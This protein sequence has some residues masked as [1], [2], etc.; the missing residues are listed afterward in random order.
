[1]GEKI[2]R[3]SLKPGYRLLWYRIE[4]ILGQGGFGITYL[5][6]DFNLDRKAAIKEYLPIELA[7]REGD[8]SVHPLT[9]NHGKQFKWGLDR[10]LSEARTLAK[11]EHPNIVRVLN[12][13][14]ANNTA[15][16]V[17]SYE[18]GESLQ[19]ILNRRKTLEEGEIMNILFPILGGLD[20]VHEMGFIHRDIKPANIFL[21]KDGSP[22]LLDFG[23]ARQAVGIQT[24]T[25]TSLISPGYA[26][27][28]QYYSK[29]DAQ[30]PWTDIYGL[31]ATLY[32]A[33]AGISP[34]DAVDR[35]RA[36]LKGGRDTFIRAAE[37]GKGRYSGRFLNAIDH[38]L[39]FKEED[40]PQ[41]ITEW[42]AEFGI[43]GEKTAGRKVSAADIPTEVAPENR[44]PQ[45]I[46]GVTQVKEAAPVKSRFRP[47]LY[48]L[49]ILLL[50]VLGYSYKDDI[51]A[52]YERGMEQQVQ[53]PVQERKV[54]PVP[55][56]PG[57]EEINKAD[58]IN[59]L[60]SDARMHFDA[61][62]LTRP[63]DNNSLHSYR[64]VL[65]LDPEN[66]AAQQGINQIT[67]KLV[68]LAQQ[69]TAADNFE[70]AENYLD[71][72]RS[73]MPDA[74]NIQL[75]QDEL[76]LR[77]AALEK[78]RARAGLLVE[79]TRKAI[80]KGDALTVLSN[81]EKARSLGV[82]ADQIDTLRKELKSRLGE[83]ASAEME[84]ARKAMDAKD[85]AKA[86]QALEKAKEY[87]RKADT[88]SLN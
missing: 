37:I 54:V 6:Y 26:P 85:T 56:E 69:A 60:L 1:M 10:F 59:N 84:N 35:S 68:S 51:R 7:V 53:A 70:K 42:K 48:F 33:V 40:R 62:R 41:S 67:D 36:I 46:A 17:M 9:E 45:A 43:P 83:L 49:S 79:E 15:Y 21:R 74:P 16:M 4:K 78:S 88:I 2:H 32:R 47:L 29:S 77:K 24:K 52:I 14:E 65:E 25:L 66:M 28:E 81:L 86:R 11:F 58:R 31:G 8:F 80:E 13:F 73:I 5:A 57:K 63:E 55:E 27:F 34:I 64:Q 23:S 75:A 20:K 44:Q 38:A 19:E 18:E 82:G 3:N 12:V 76:N 22:V 30:G 61:L 87:K 72:A 71:Q 39:E 50:A